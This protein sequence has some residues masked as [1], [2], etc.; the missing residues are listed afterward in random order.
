MSYCRFSSDNYRSDVYVY[1]NGEESYHTHVAGNRLLI[2]PI[3]QWPHRWMPPFGAA[4]NK[5]IRQLEYPNK[6]LA[7]CA[8]IFYNAVTSYNRLH[9]WSLRVIPRISI[10][11]TMAGESFTDNSIGEC[12]I[13]LIDLRARGYHIPQGAIDRLTEELVFEGDG[14][15]EMFRSLFSAA[16]HLS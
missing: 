12:I 7:L 16:K 15:E 13:R 8:T 5:D 4:W 2:S 11:D 9:H 6:A 3:P 10:K 14:R 1:S